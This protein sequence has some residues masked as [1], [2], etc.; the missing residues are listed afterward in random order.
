MLLNAIISSIIQYENV[1][2]LIFLVYQHGLFIKVLVFRVQYV[3]LLYSFLNDGLELLTLFFP[4]TS[5]QSNFYKYLNRKN[6][7]PIMS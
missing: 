4:Q 6:Y 5:L 3:E 2:L 1:Q 7:F